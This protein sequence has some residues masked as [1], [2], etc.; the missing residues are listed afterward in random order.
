MGLKGKDMKKEKSGKHPLYY[1]VVLVIYGCLISV[2]SSFSG[3]GGVMQTIKNATAKLDPETQIPVVVPLP[4]DIVKV[5]ETYQGGRFY[6]EAR[7]HRI[8]RFKCSACHNNKEVMA[9]NAARISHA[10]IVLN[11]GV[12]DGPAACNTCHN[13]AD[14][15]HLTTASNRTID[16]DHAYDMC[17][18]CHFRQKK[19]WIGGAHGRRVSHW[20]GQ[21]VIKN[22]TSCHNPHS[23]RFKKRMPATYSVPLQ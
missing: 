22:C 14:R 13:A 8:G 4:K 11:H 5:H 21:R 6:T 20:A 7:K 9:L 3:E 23:P 2:P 19:D 15:D 17:G 16:M 10:D 18:Q 1:L 12:K